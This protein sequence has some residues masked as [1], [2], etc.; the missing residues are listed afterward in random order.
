MHTVNEYAL[1]VYYWKW[2]LYIVYAKCECTTFHFL[3]SPTSWNPLSDYYKHGIRLCF[4][5]KRKCHYCSI[6]I[7]FVCFIVFSSR[8]AVCT[9]IYRNDQLF[10][11]HNFQH[12]FRP[13]FCSRYLFCSGFGWLSSSWTA[14]TLLSASTIHHLLSL[15]VVDT[16]SSFSL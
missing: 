16:F 7:N 15:M 12:I 11:I 9:Y 6:H 4:I 3:I 14:K 10:I 13:K 5:W 2:R 8:Y 1:E